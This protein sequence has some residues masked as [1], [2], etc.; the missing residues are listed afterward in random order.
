MGKLRIKPDTRRL[1]K[2]T[3]PLR[4][5]FIRKYDEYYLRR[6]LKRIRFAGFSYGVYIEG[7]WVHNDKGQARLYIHTRIGCRDIGD[8]RK[9]IHLG[10]R[11]DYL[12]L[13]AG[14]YVSEKY[15]LNFIRQQVLGN[16]EHELD[17]HMT[18]D[19]H[20]VFDPH[21]RTGRRRVL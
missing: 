13:P 3:G 10:S 2:P 18:V 14:R 4:L 12:Q 6:F 15:L 11:Y 20:R 16:L 8:R 9:Q 1:P 17:E 5:G 21:S 7:G 19:S